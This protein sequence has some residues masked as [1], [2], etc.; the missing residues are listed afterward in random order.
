MRGF[1]CFGPKLFRKR[2]VWLMALLGLLPAAVYLYYG[3]VERDF[4]GRQFAGRF[5]P[6]LLLSPLNYLHWA[7]TANQA[8]GALAIA[9]GVVGF[10][11]VRERHFR[12]MLAGL[13]LGYLVYGC[14]FDYHVATHDYYQLPLIA[15]VAISISSGVDLVWQQLS[16]W[17][18]RPLG[19]WALVAAF[20]YVLLSGAW[21]ARS[22]LAGVDYRPQAA[23]WTRIGAALDHGPNVVALTQDYGS[24]L[25]YWGWQNANIWPST[26]DAEYRTARGGRIDFNELF[27]KLTLG[28]KY[29]LVTDF[30]E[31][32]RQPD[33]QARLADFAV[34]AQGEGYI[35][36]D[37]EAPRGS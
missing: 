18:T 6:A 3:I 2:Q 7:E 31:L 34:F 5:I 28:N 14:F 13:W 21:S 22:Q 15:L 24:R 10:F 19:Q 33:L 32:A 36:Y 20:A 12:W 27:S 8:A 30:D 37:L 9:A 4:L 23:V 29:F 1:Q 11:L 25:A 16:A 26:G 17:L 35:I